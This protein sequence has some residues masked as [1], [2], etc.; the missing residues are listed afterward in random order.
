VERVKFEIAAIYLNQIPRP[1]D[2]FSRCM[3]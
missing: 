3:V 2:N 1:E